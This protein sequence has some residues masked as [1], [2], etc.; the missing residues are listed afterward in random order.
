M[1]FIPKLFLKE[2]FT[3]LDKESITYSVNIIL[4]GIALSLFSYVIPAVREG[5]FK[6]LVLNE[7]ILDIYWNTLLILLAVLVPLAISAVELLNRKQFKE[8]GPGIYFKFIFDLKKFFSLITLLSF[9]FLFSVT[10]EPYERDEWTHMFFFHLMTFYLWVVTFWYFI[11]VIRG[12]LKL[13]IDREFIKHLSFLDLKDRP[14]DSA[15]M[16]S[17]KWNSV[18]KT[19]SSL[20]PHWLAKALVIFWE[21]QKQGFERGLFFGVTA[22]FVGFADNLLSL[23]E[24]AMRDESDWIN[25][26]KRWLWFHEE[27]FN[28]GQENPYAVFRR[29]LK[30][31]R[32]AYKQWM[33]DLGFKDGRTFEQGVANLQGTLRGII[34]RLVVNELETTDDFFFSLFKSLSDHIKKDPVDREYISSL[35]IYSPVFE[36]SS[37][38]ALNKYE[39]GR[40]DIGFP[41]E[42]RVLVDELDKGNLLRDIWLNKFSEW[43]SRRIDH[44]KKE[45]DD[46]LNGAVEM[47]FPEA[48]SSWIALALGYAR[49]SWGGSRVNSLC[50][51]QPNFGMGT[52]GSSYSY[53]YTKTEKENTKLMWAQ[54]GREIE[55]R[56]DNA[57]RIIKR[58]GFFGEDK[59]I[60]SIEIELE[61]LGG[62]YEN[63]S[64][65]EMNRVRMLK[66]VNALVQ[67][68]SSEFATK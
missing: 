13:V 56:Q 67:I 5:L 39:K 9:S 40:D 4:C 64:Y 12:T 18:W 21:K 22:L 6:L 20:R 61:G 3:V 30:F 43:A 37:L 29:L 49:L 7:K 32:L 50:Q 2:V 62:K 47:L 31:Y 27:K 42:W 14:L 59:D 16:V 8:F 26:R 66:L 68:N 35:P 24:N 15:D 52:T 38:Y 54:L 51:W 65:Q 60:Q 44:G 41:S 28:D 11:D 36:H 53:D 33:K 23:K 17:E 57:A 10:V 46:K 63:D 25:S 48:D 58:L 45:W 19:A 55:V 1:R 34:E